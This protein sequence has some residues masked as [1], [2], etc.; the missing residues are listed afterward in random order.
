MGSRYSGKLLVL[1]DGRTLYSPVFSG[2]YWEAQDVVLEDVERIEVIRGSGGTLWGAN[3]VNGVI[4]IISRPAKDT[5][6]TYTEVKAGNQESGLVLRYGRALG[7]D[8]HFRIYAK[9]DRYEALET[10]SSAPT[11]DA[12]SQKRVGVRVDLAPGHGNTVT[13]QGDAYETNAQQTTLYMSEQTLKASFVPDTVRLSGVNV[14][15]RWKHDESPSESWQLQAYVDHARLNDVS[16]SQHVDTIDLE[17]QHRL[18]LKADHDLTW[19]M[20]ARRVSQNILGGFTVSMN[21]NQLTETI[22]SGFVQDEIRLRKDWSLTLGS[23]LE[24]NGFTGFETQPSA[25][26]QWRATPTDNFWGAVSRSVQTPSLASTAADTHV[27]NERLPGLGDAVLAVRGKPEL[28]SEVMLSRELGYRGQFGPDV[29]LDASVFYNTYD[30]LVSREVGA[31]SFEPYPVLPIQ[32]DN[33]MMGKTYGLE[34]TGNWQVSPNWRLHGSYSWLRMGLKA[35]PGGQGMV[36]FGEAGSSPKHMAQ[37]HSLHNL[38]NHFELDAS[39]YFNSGLSFDRDGRQFAIDRYTRFD[40]RLGWRPSYN[41]ELNLIG[42]N[43]LVRRHTEY[44]GD[45][46]RA[47]EIPRS[48]LLQAKWKF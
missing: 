20:G 5:Q 37:L 14:L 47:S 9:G 7:D 25:R 10:S 38:G 18:P 6:G 11:H 16:A 19:G 24:H 21:P 45:D 12:W 28:R 35:K 26:L 30:H 1:L 23:K 42:R 27:G 15:A 33:L 13:V 48:L 31:L 44:Y 34:L 46:V 43:L 22:Y 8:G 41:T 39:L 2:T 3:A 36:A 29:N 17:W 4:N 32:F 40:L